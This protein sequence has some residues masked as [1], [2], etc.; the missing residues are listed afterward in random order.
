[1]PDNLMQQLIGLSLVNVMELLAFGTVL[2][3]LQWWLPARDG[4]RAW[5][6]SS[7]LDLVYSFILTLST[8]FFIIVPVTLVGWFVEAIPAV[9]QV[10]DS[11]VGDMPFYVQVVLAIVVVDVVGYWR[12][13]MMHL[14]WLW[15]LHAIHHS[16]RRLDWLSTERFH[17][18]N[19]VIT[20]TINIV[21]V[22]LL[23][24]QA[25]TAYSSIAR[26]FYNLF[27]HANIRLDYGPLGYLLVSPRF[28]HWH[29][30]V[31]AQAR[32]KNF[33][34][35]FSLTDLVFGTFHLPRD[36]SYPQAVGEPEHMPER[37][38]AQFLYPFRAWGWLRTL[39]D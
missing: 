36:K 9:V 35:F 29:H 38:G 2:L 32:D 19:H 24:G 5:D 18:L 16:S 14:R 37:F 7:A 1:M 4:Q 21:V 15:P 39:A 13:R 25:V 28:H 34:T 17:I 23:F 11:I 12:H 30:A 8:P 26:R 31:D 6:R 22:Q 27:I 20:A 3:L 33:S 10:R